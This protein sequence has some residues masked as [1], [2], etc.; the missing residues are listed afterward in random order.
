[1]AV[2]GNKARMWEL[3]LRSLPAFATLFRHALLELGEPATASKRE[4]VQKLA[5]KVGF[6]SSSFLQLLEIREHKSDPK[7]VDVNDLFARYLKEIEQV[8]SAVDKML[9]SAA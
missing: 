2:A 7:T 3:L 6:D 1:M 8:T 9:D 4:A 5:A